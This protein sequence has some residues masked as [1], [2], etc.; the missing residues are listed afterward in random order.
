MSSANNISLKPFLSNLAEVFDGDMEIE[1]TARREL[2]KLSQANFSAQRY[3]LTAAI[4]YHILIP[5]KSMAR[6]SV[7]N[8]TS[9]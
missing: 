4:R 2:R 8:F 5:H 7:S 6:L 1:K 9:N 3:T